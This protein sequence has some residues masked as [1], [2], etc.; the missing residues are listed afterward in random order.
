MSRTEPDRPMVIGAGGLLGR[1]LTLRLERAFPGTIAATRSEIDVTDPFRLETEVER[2]RPTVVINC[3]AWTDV[4]GC[5]RDPDRAM[6]V[7]AEGAANVARAAAAAGCRI[8]Q[9]STDFVFDGTSRTPYV[10]SDAPN[11]IAEYGRSKLEG[12]RRVAAATADHVIVRTAWLY[13]AGGRTFVDRIRSRA[14]AGEPLRVVTDQVGSPTWVEDL[15]EGIL[16][17]LHTTYRGIVHVTNRGACS[18][19]ALAEAVLQAIGLRGRVPLEAT[20]TT[21]APGV[22]ERPAFAALDTTLY[23]RLTSVTMRPWEEALRDYLAS[24]ATARR[25]GA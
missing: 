13:G 16:R 15:S 22:A 6:E 17:L 20:R 25:D 10:E 3:A 23:E 1:A 7:N 12:E 14:V 24:L 5:T 4:D 18:R 19:H 2:L 11:P 8:I 21:P 9:V